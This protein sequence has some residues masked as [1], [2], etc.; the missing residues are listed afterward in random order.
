M[1]KD[2]IDL[3]DLSKGPGKFGGNQMAAY[4]YELSLDGSMADDESGNVEAPTGWFARF[5]KR[6]L[7]EDSQGFVDVTR[8]ANEQAAL[9]AFDEL[10]DEYVKWDSQDG[11]S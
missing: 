9:A 11:E 3:R 10:M 8:L 1:I 2:G 6:I 4:L 5:G 7:T